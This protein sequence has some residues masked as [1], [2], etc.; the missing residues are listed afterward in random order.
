MWK[1]LSVLFTGI[2]VSFYYFSFEFS[3]LP[4]INTKMGLAVV[5]IFLVTINLIKKRGFYCPH[6]LV[7]IVVMAVFVSLVGV[8]SVILNNTADY[9]YATYCVSML[10]WISGAYTVCCL[11]KRVH[12]ELNVENVTVYLTIVSCI[13]CILALVI[14]SNIAVKSFVDTYIMQGQ[15]FLTEV[16]RIYGI[17]ASLDT[18]GVRFSACLI[19]LMYIID[20]NKFSMTNI[21]IFLSFL[22]Y[23]LIAIIGNMVARTTIVGVSL[24]LFYAVLAFRPTRVSSAF[25]RLLRVVVMLIIV[26]V[27]II[28]FLYDN[29]QQFY[30]LSRFA[31]EGFFN[32]AETGEWQ[33]DSND[34]LKTM[35]VFPDNIKSWLIGDGYFSNPY[36]TDPFYVGPLTDGYYMG[37]DI[38]YCRFIFYFGLI[39]LAAFAY[40]FIVVAREVMSVLPSYKILVLF[41]L[42]LG[43]IIWLKVATD[44]FIVFA[45]FLCIGNMQAETA[46]LETEP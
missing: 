38:G 23:V 27:P 40:F 41:I 19:L 33:I 36:N 21:Q 17:G 26:L 31:F 46:K 15:D 4:G 43:F 42:F 14:D 29:S 16:K 32:L 18:A 30:G 10:V 3:F 2:I 25:F 9:A 35:I 39:G 1:I 8:I 45:L 44:L 22:A 12:H 34:K 6:N 5:G 24:S 7:R 13:Q 11:I 28:I 20:K 37:T